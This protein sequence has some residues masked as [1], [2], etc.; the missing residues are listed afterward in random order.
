MDTHGH[1]LDLT[2][3][4]VLRGV[5]VGD[6]RVTHRCDV[7]EADRALALLTIVRLGRIGTSDFCGRIWKKSWTQR[8]A[9]CR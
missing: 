5:V 9:L 6:L 3:P 7:L 1:D 2:V 4:E 8:L